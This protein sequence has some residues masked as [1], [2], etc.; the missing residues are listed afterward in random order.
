MLSALF[1]TA[2]VT[3]MPSTAQTTSPWTAQIVDTNAYAYTN[4]YCPLVLDS[5]GNPHFA[6][7]GFRINA[8][9]FS[10]PLVMYASW[11]GTGFNLQ[12]IAVGTA[13]SLVLDHA[14]NPHILYGAGSEASSFGPL[15]Y[16]SW[17]GSSWARGT[18]DN[19]YL[20]GF[21]VVALDSADK[22]H[23]AYTDGQTVKYA[24]GSG[25]S[26]NRVTVD[27]GLNTPFYL[28]LAL[29]AENTPYIMYQAPGSE[30]VDSKTGLNYST[31]NVRLATKPYLHWLVENVSL[32]Q[33]AQRWGNLV[34]DSKGQPHFI[35]S[36]YHYVSAKNMTT[37]KSLLYMSWDGSAWIS[38]TVASG[39][40]RLVL[41]NLA[42]DSNDNPH[43]TYRQ[44]GLQYASWTGTYWNIQSMD[45]GETD[46]TKNSIGLSGSL[47]IDS[48]G[49]PHMSYVGAPLTAQIE[50]RRTYANYA[51]ANMPPLTP[52]P[53]P[54]L[55]EGTVLFEKL[56]A[57]ITAIVIAL[58]VTTVLMGRKR[59]KS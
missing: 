12:Q 28:S 58:V 8:D 5:S 10:T 18:V 53:T 25:S 45:L 14:D 57:I 43:L 34:L 55:I 17:T 15:M 9:R 16:A 30:Y 22:P 6:Y 7:T 44:N 19:S 33:P 23:V 41:G 47:L 49:N 54:P 31:V 38:Q 50:S 37:V 35:C 39:T 1:L 24:T 29:N 21:G 42:F 48:N 26:W 27:K 36:Q 2:L 4:G 46:I 51:T 59:Q 11:N 20:H 13:F 40:E 56:P 52:T 3:A 32:P